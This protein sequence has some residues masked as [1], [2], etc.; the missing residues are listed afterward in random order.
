MPVRK[1]PSRRILSVLQ[2]IIIPLLWFGLTARSSVAQKPELVV[3]AGHKAMVRAL[4]LSSDN[5]LLASAGA[6]KTIIVWD[7]A[8]EKQLT[9]LS[10]HEAWVFALAFSP[11]RRLLASG[12]YDGVIKIWNLQ[13][14]KIQFEVSQSYSINSLSF[15]PDGNIL[16]IATADKVIKL[17][18]MTTGLMK[19]PL[20]GHTAAVTQVLF[21]PLSQRLFSSSL[22]GTLRVWDFVTMKA[23][24]V[25]GLRQGIAGFAFSQD[26]R[27]IALSAT[28]GT[29][30]VLD[31]SGKAPAV[32]VVQPQKRPATPGFVD[33]RRWRMIFDTSLYAPGSLAFVSDAKLAFVDG[34]NLTVWDL[35][36]NK[37]L[38]STEIADGR[39]AYALIYDQNLN[40]LICSDGLDIM[41]LNVPSQVRHYLPRGTSGFQAVAFTADGKTLVAISE[42]GPAAWSVR[43]KSLYTE[44]DKLSGAKGVRNRSI[45]RVWS[46]GITINIEKSANDIR[47][48]GEKGISV[49]KGHAKPVT[50]IAVSPNET[51]LASASGDGTILLWDLNSRKVIKKLNENATLLQ[52][53]P[54]GKLL[55]K[56]DHKEIKLWTIGDLAKEPLTIKADVSDS[57]LFSPKSEVLAAAVDEIAPEASGSKEESDRTSDCRRMV[58]RST[59][60]GRKLNL[61]NINTGDLLHSFPIK[62]RS[63]P[64]SIDWFTSTKS[65]CEP[66]AYTLFGDFV[67]LHTVNGPVAF[68]DDGQLIASSVV[69]YST[70]RH[71]IGIWNTHSGEEVHLLTD[72]TDAIRSIAFSPN[73]KILASAS[74]DSTLKLWSTDTGKEAATVID[75]GKDDWVIYTPDGH[76]DT[77]LD[78]SEIGR[79][80]W[81]WPTD[82]LNRLSMRVF[83][84]DYYEPLLLQKTLRG[85]PLNPVGDISSLNRVQ[86]LVSVKWVKAD[87]PSTVQVTVEVRSV[88]SKT[89]FD[90]NG[91][92]MQSGVFDVRLFRDKQLVSRSP[93]NHPVSE[94]SPQGPISEKTTQSKWSEL[95]RQTHALKLD[96]HGSASLTFHNIRLPFRREIKEVE[97]SAYA[98]NGDRVK[99]ETS[100]P[101][102]YP[103]PRTRGNLVRRAYVITVGVNANQS[104][105]DLSYAVKS[106]SDVQQAF[107]AK[108]SKAYQVISVPI[109]STRKSD[110]PQ[111]ALAQANKE[112]IKTVLDILAGRTRVRTV[113]SEQQIPGFA[114]LRAASPDDLV[115]LYICSHGYVD[116]KGKF[117]VIPYNT[118]RPAGVTE[119]VLDACLSNPD[120]SPRCMAAQ[121]F[122]DSAI[123][124]DDLADWM[125]HV[126]AGETLMVLDSCYSGA[127]ATTGREFRPG[128]LE[129]RGFAPLAYDKGILILAASQPDK[130]AMAT[131][132]IGNGRSL[133]SDAL[134]SIATADKQPRVADW[135]HK[136]GSVVPQTYQRLYPSIS[137]DDI[138]L[139]VVLD[140]IK[141]RSSS[142]NANPPNR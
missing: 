44:E 101:Y 132:L 64:F 104:Q 134:V 98:F 85:E 68:S 84:Q 46:K 23:E 16:A 75:L 115:V 39:G 27:H 50:A 41:L 140:F 2:W 78:L 37:K 26:G 123:S 90:Q 106:A 7:L 20:E 81:S 40:Q 12:S 124:S 43:G 56:G 100:P 74:W 88:I 129:D 35:P 71:Q 36:S 137:V 52:F 8:A 113:G 125:N 99:S 24:Q 141:N 128:A 28:G 32:S 77:S 47:L 121:R 30:G 138:Q 45:I 69:D 131:A 105:W 48:V 117:Y 3:Q 25:Q 66:F 60:N 107:E 10:G 62:R 51:I 122:V 72:H 76:F 65:N 103:I 91:H 63:E 70:G 111:V 136:A 110:S 11:N 133:L 15:S 17:W 19:S 33:Y 55:A 112:T 53:S 80:S 86:P 13:D 108:L 119:E 5:K 118:G 92:P 139:P 4:A 1:S 94:N 83:M 38:F 142:N 82:P 114:A 54:D 22:D 73:G 96:A 89:Q 93:I 61:W 14:K 29:I 57:M 31:F 42:I 18:D 9:S 127:V 135:A 49:L 116:P 67:P 87:G 34:F 130:P 21:H 120:E 59:A 97:F 58:G 95:W 126:D 109:V 6:D 79:L 102:V